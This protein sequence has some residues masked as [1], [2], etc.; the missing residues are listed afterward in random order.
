[1]A[2]DVRCDRDAV[3]EG[4]DTRSAEQ[5]LEL[6]GQGR[7]S[8]LVT[9]GV[10][11]KLGFEPRR[12]CPQRCL[13]PPRLPFRHFGPGQSA[14]TVADAPRSSR[15]RPAEPGRPGEASGAGADA[16]LAAPHNRRPEGPPGRGGPSLD[17]VADDPVQRRDLILIER[18]RDGDLDAFNDLVVLL[19]GPAVRAHRPDGPGPRPGADCVQEA[20]F[21][22]FRNLRGVPRRQR[23][24]LAQ[25][26]RDQC[27]DGHPARPE[28]PAGPALPGARGRELAAAGRRGGRSRHDRAHDRAPRGAERRARARSPTTSEPRS[29]C[30]TSRAT[31]TRRS[32]R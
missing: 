1:M 21:S 24:V 26:D 32:R 15:T 29:S 5:R 22:A 13:R 20:F 8:C 17:E 30:S 10:V 16:R 19:P 31:T 9:P 12:G 3:A 23:Q 25:P 7:R 4:L 11:P 2:V 28:A 27:R 18:A 14:D 6:V